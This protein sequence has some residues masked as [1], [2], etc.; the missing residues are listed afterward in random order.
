M[1]QVEASAEP[2]G[3]PRLVTLPATWDDA[4]AEALAV[5]SPG[6]GAVSLAAASSI[7][8]GVIGQRA[9]QAGASTDIVLAMIR[10]A[11]STLPAMPRRAA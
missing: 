7:W 2:D 9:K 11:V 1:R 5:L 8:L 6:E 3:K 4:A 10:C